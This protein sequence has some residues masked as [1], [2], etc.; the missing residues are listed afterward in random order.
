MDTRVII[1]LGIA[2]LIVIGLTIWLSQRQQ[3]TDA[4][5]EQLSSVH[6]RAGQE[7]AHRHRAEWDLEDGK[8][9]VEQRRIRTL[10][11]D[12]RDGLTER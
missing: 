12:E 3:R 6:D 11:P 5:R 1:A 9:R 10:S 4:R 2:S 7:H 8:M